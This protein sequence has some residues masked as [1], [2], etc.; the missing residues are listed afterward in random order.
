MV[1]FGVTPLVGKGGWGFA[2]TASS[3]S[4]LSEELEESLAVA[5]LAAG[6][7]A[8]VEVVKPVDLPADL[9]FFSSSD[10]LESE[11]LD[12]FAFF[13]LGTGFEG[14]LSVAGVT[15][16][17][18]VLPVE[19]VAAF[20]FSSSEL[21]ELS[22]E[23]SAFFFFTPASPFDIGTTFAV[24]FAAGTAEASSS[25][26]LEDEL[27]SFPFLD[28]VAAAVFFAFAAG[29]VPFAT[30]LASAGFFA[31][32]SSDELS[33]ELLSFF[34]ALFAGVAWFTAIGGFFAVAIC[35][36]ASLSELSE[37][38][39]DSFFPFEGTAGATFVEVLTFGV[40][41]IFTFSFADFPSAS[42]SELSE[43]ESSLESPRGSHLGPR[44]G[45]LCFRLLRR[46]GGSRSFGC[47]FSVFLI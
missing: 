9:C 8:G 25:D 35:F 39:D 31:S 47:N 17:G 30:F 33:L 43:S 29:V 42:L 15:G 28:G 26:E 16:F 14:V 22:D 38:D 27:D 1:A 13:A 40:G 36:P 41:P 12:S 4:E 37:E 21:S 32:S 23:E 10:E 5:D 19:E 20:F 44:R 2:L 24:C 7:A 18:R 3:S 45:P 11:E 34:P 6:L 46:L